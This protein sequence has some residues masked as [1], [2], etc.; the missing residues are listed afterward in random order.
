[1]DTFRITKSSCINWPV[2]KSAS[3]R[4]DNKNRHFLP[5]TNN[6]LHS[7]P[8]LLEIKPMGKVYHLQP[9]RK[10][11]FDE[12][13]ELLPI[14]RRITEDAIKRAGAIANLLSYYPVSAEEGKRLKIQFQGIIKEWGEKV[15]KLGPFPKGLW[16]VDFDNGSGYYCWRFP[17][18]VLTHYHSYA[19]GFAGRIPLNN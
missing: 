7:F 18:E 1:M 3:F 16:L 2:K 12:A 15:Q 17:E 19:E 8:S 13:Q 4:S 5:S 9:G 14:V 10:F 6:F 11:S